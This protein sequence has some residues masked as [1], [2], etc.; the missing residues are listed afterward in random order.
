MLCTLPRASMASTPKEVASV[1]EGHN[2]PLAKEGSDKPLAKDG[3]WLRTTMSP[4]PQ[5]QLAAYLMQDK[6][7]HLAT[8]TSDPIHCA[9]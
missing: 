8:R 4:L 9:R 2:K 1:E 7:E 3:N 6:D 5:G